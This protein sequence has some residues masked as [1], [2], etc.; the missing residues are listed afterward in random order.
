MFRFPFLVSVSGFRFRLRFPLAVSVSG[1]RFPFPVSVSASG[2]FT[3]DLPALDE[4]D[5]FQENLQKI[6][7][8]NDHW[9]DSLDNKRKFGLNHGDIGLIVLPEGKWIDMERTR[10]NAVEIFAPGWHFLGWFVVMRAMKFF[11]LYSTCPNR[12]MT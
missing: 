2:S 1:F 10:T 3:Q 11:S 7:K 12:A 8:V 6:V 9:F 5:L 4:T